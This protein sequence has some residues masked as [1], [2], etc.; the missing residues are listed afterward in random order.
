VGLAVLP[1]VSLAPG[2]PLPASVKGPAMELTVA[3]AAFLTD[4]VDDGLKRS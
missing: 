3:A 1:Q 2:T 4:W